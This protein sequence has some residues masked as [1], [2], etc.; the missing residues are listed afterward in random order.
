MFAVGQTRID[1]RTA[2][3]AP[4]VNIRDYISP[5]HN[6]SSAVLHRLAQIIMLLRHCQHTVTIVPSVSPTILFKLHS[7]IICLL[8]STLF[9]LSLLRVPGNRG[10]CVAPPSMTIE[11]VGVAKL[12]ILATSQKLVR[13]PP[14][15]SAG[16]TKSQ[17][18]VLL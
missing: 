15:Q 4:E 14:P 3:D 9:D 17:R 11:V 7:T 2:A 12:Q 18:R 16:T 8:L 10:F 1:R 5:L 6:V 13:T